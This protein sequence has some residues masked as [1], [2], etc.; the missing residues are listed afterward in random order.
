[1]IQFLEAVSTAG[2]DMG[3]KAYMAKRLFLTLLVLFG[4]TLISFTITR[5]APSDP[6]RLWVGRSDSE[7]NPA[8]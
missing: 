5:V 7:P 8:S 3:F 4:V 6:A 2:S 1:M